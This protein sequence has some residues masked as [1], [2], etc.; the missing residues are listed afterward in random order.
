[1]KKITHIFVS[2]NFKHSSAQK[3][4]KNAKLLPMTTTN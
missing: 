2:K 1:M 3:Y 4:P